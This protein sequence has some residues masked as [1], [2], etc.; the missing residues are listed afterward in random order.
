MEGGGSASAQ[1]GLSLPVPT[2]AAALAGGAPF[3]LGAIR[4]YDYIDAAW[5]GSD[6]SPR[7]VRAAEAGAVLTRAR[8]RDDV[9]VGRVEVVGPPA[10][11][12]ATPPPVPAAAGYA[13]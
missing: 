2:N 1:H 3:A 13:P 11:R 8:R 10:D 4:L 7:T 12:A 9:D 5:N 6:C